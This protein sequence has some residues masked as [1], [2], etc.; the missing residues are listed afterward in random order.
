MQ[1]KLFLLILVSFCSYSSVKI[2]LAKF[3]Q[4]EFQQ[5]EAK[6]FSGETKYQLHP[7]G[8]VVEAKSRNAAS[9]LVLKKRIDIY[10]TPFMNWR[11]KVTKPLIA[12]PE[13]SKK[14]DDFAARVYVVIESGMFSLSSKALNYV[15]SSSNSKGEHWNNP[16]VGSQVKM[17]AL[18]DATS[19]LDSWYSEKRNVYQ[20]LIRLFGDK[21]SEKENLDSYQYIDVIAIMTDTDDS[22]S[23]AEALYGSI[24]FTAE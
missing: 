16:Y 5:W 2:E 17:F 1:N 13:Q 8:D 4:Q 18:R 12:L 14:G 22:S 3:N 6:S 20:D 7:T 19:S 21:G 15:W 11:W 24:S 9:G 10:K 23:Y